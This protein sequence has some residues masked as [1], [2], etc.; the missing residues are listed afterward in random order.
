MLVLAM[1]GAGLAPA[2]AS[3][4][5]PMCAAMHHDCAQTPRFATCCCRDEQPPPAEG[6]SI[7][8]KI[9]IQP[10]LD[11]AISVVPAPVAIERP[12]LTFAVHTSPPHQHLVDLPTLL[13]SLLI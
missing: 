9:E 12:H 3:V 6:V 4:G 2:F 13:G 1:L 7:Q 10:D 5:R 8:S 11:G